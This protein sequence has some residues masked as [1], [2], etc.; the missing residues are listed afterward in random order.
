LTGYVYVTNADSNTVS[1]ILDDP[2]PANIKWV[3][4]IDVGEYPQ[5]VDVDV[6]TNTIYVGNAESR[7]LTVISGATHTVIKTIP[8][9]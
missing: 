6:K 5:G 4:D 7:D 8:L 9:D 3:K 2:N 1:V